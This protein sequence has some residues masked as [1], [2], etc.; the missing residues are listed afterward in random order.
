[1]HRP[2]R[3]GSARFGSVRSLT[4]AEQRMGGVLTYPLLTPSTPPHQL[5][6]R[7]YSLHS[8]SQAG[9]ISRSVSLSPPCR[10]LCLSGSSRHCARPLSW[11][12]AQGADLCSALNLPSAAHRA[13]H[14]PCLPLPLLL[15]RAMF[16]HRYD[17]PLIFSDCAP[18]ESLSSALDA[19][20]ALDGAVADLFARMAQRV[21]QQQRMVDALN[22]R[23]ST[24][25][26]RVQTLSAHPSRVTTLF[27][28]AKYPAPPSLPS[29]QSVSGVQQVSA[30]G[31][32]HV[33][34][35]VLREDWTEEERGWRPPPP[36]PHLIPR[37]DRFIAAAATDTSA[38][39]SHLSK[40][41]L[42]RTEHVTDEAAEGLG[43]LPSYL[44]SISSILLFNSDTNPYKAMRYTDNLEGTAGEDRKVEHT[45][46]AAAPRSI[47]EGADLPT[48]S[49]YQ[50]EYRPLLGDLP[51]FNLPANLPLGML[52]DIHFGSNA[53]TGA[54]TAAQLSIAPSAQH[55][56]NLA[57]PSLSQLT[58]STLPTHHSTPS[59]PSTAAA[60]AGAPGSGAGAPLP[61]PPPPPLSAA[62]GAPAAAPLSG[63]DAPLA[64]P[65]AA[66]PPPPPPPPAPD[67][68]PAPPLA[69]SSTSSGGGDKRSSLLDAIRNR[70]QVKLRKVV[71]EEGEGEG[72]EGGGAAEGGAGGAGE[73]GGGGAGKA[74]GKRKAESG[75]GD[76]MSALKAQLERR[77]QALMGKQDTAGGA[78]GGGG[79][80]GGEAGAR[81]SASASLLT[82][83]LLP[84]LDR[85]GA[86]S[87][88]GEE[89]EA[90]RQGQKGLNNPTVMHALVAAHSKKQTDDE[91]E[92]S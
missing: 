21:G 31:G 11:G 78:G 86:S 12:G 75:G 13:V 30:V 18:A 4:A 60:A 72:G 55:T 16:G 59:H 82:S 89:E 38:L 17:V 27:S 64:P 46:P 15:L 22:S 77:K 88:S 48:F 1:M 65:L 43:R 84:K 74:G 58:L 40:A 52:A 44:P 25:A 87:G 28:A 2:N 85:K 57:L 7:S 71:K 3:F 29:F 62:F 51:T 37:H 73:G 56:T 6:C 42:T 34:V 45:G 92:W 91:E 63:S 8:A 83:A 70:S 47:V 23:I 14:R 39:F 32:R 54:D 5:Q 35:R 79:G 80:G 68:P 50:F 10:L 61:P 76:M 67:A 41:R 81:P 19:L 20:Q 69:S 24:A 36:P 90:A 26:T 53:A 66:L 33:D 9:A 49:A